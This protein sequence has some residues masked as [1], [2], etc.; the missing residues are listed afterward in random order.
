[1]TGEFPAQRAS[2]AE[3]ASILWRHH[4][5][6]FSEM[7]NGTHLLGREP[8]FNIKIAEREPTFNIKIAELTIYMH[9]Y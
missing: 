4:E 7:E 6:Q 1:M 5:S 2:Y 3:N 9:T 8:T